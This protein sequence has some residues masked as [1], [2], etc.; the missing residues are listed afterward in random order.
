MIKRIL[1]IVM[2]TISLC[3][4]SADNF[5]NSEGIELYYDLFYNPSQEMPIMIITDY[6]GM[7]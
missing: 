6:W 2:I 3:L 1:I 5:T 4:S 7:V